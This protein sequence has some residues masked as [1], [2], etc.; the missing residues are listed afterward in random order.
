[1][2]DP[3]NAAIFFGPSGGGVFASNL[4]LLLTDDI[5]AFSDSPTGAIGVIPEPSTL[6]LLASGLVGMGTL[7][8]KRTRPKGA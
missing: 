2:F 6:L 3:V 1:M 4:G 5:N 7:T 8:R